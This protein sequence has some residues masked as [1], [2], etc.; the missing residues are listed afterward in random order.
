MKISN[1]MRFFPELMKNEDPTAFNTLA[2]NSVLIS[3]GDIIRKYAPIDSQNESFWHT[4]NANNDDKWVKFSFDGGI[5]YVLKFQFKNNLVL[6]IRKDGQF[7]PLDEIEFDLTSYSVSV[8][9]AAKN[10]LLSLTSIHVETDSSTNDESTWYSNISNFSY[11][12][13]EEDDSKVL[14]IKLLA[15]VPSNSS[16]IMLTIG[17]DGSNTNALAVSSPIFSSTTGAIPTVYDEEFG[18]CNLLDNKI[19]SI[20]CLTKFEDVNSLSLKVVSADETVSGNIVL[21]FGCGSSNYDDGTWPSQVIPVDNVEKWVTIN[22]PRSI[23][24]TLVIK[25][26][27]DSVD[28]TL[29]SNSELNDV[30]ISAVITNIRMERI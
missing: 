12:F 30:I 5:T 7:N 18:I 13:I 29:K 3:R 10:G 15:D 2:W 27:F 19:S 23:T 28:D 25:R 26:I 9:E 20:T 6:K 16:G 8:F 24:G 22:V 14:K 4:G 11:S 21:A 1:P 17:V